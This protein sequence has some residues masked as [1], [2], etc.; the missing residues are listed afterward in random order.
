MSAS[1]SSD[2]AVILQYDD[3]WNPVFRT[4]DRAPLSWK[5]L[6][7]IIGR[8]DQ[9]RCPGLEAIV[10]PDDM[11]VFRVARFDAESGILDVVPLS[12]LL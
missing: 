8:L 2:P 1:T 11:V 9:A 12:D 3:G 7:A 10:G 4:G 6:Q 5:E